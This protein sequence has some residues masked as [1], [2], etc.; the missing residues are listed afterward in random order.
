LRSFHG[1]QTF[2]DLRELSL[3]VKSSTLG[4]PTRYEFTPTIA[5]A[6]ANGEFWCRVKS[7]LEAIGKPVF[8]ERW[9]FRIDRWNGLFERGANEPEWFARFDGHVNDPDRAS[10]GLD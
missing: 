2:G 7:L 10:K 9:N 4:A 6:R 1:S 8:E 5:I 3:A